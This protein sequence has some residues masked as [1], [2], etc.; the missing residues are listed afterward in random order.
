M[1][2]LPN[3]S[4][5]LGEDIRSQQRTLSMMSAVLDKISL[6]FRDGQHSR[7]WRKQPWNMS[8]Y[9]GALMPD[10][11]RI[12]LMSRDQMYFSRFWRRWV[13]WSSI[14]WLLRSIL[15]DGWAKHRCFTIHTGNRP[16]PWV[17]RNAMGLLTST[18]RYEWNSCSFIPGRS[19]CGRNTIL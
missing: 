7:Y 10:W 5:K 6:K 12:C 19:I 1:N 16:V 14:L 9:G 3:L 13:N 17:Q 11:T 18:V 15:R 8:L 2:S 4:D